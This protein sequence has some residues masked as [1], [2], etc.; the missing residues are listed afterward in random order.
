VELFNNNPDEERNLLPKNGIVNYYGKLF[1]A[2]EA[3]DFLE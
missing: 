2:I 1:S 3:N